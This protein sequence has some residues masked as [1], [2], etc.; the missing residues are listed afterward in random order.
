MLFDC[1]GARRV[2]STSACTPFCN[3]LVGNRKPN[4][5]RFSSGSKF[6]N[7]PGI[8]LCRGTFADDTY[9]LAQCRRHIVGMVEKFKL[10][11]DEIS[12]PA[13]RK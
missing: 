5:S 1:V 13:N 12:Q 10:D 9:Q 2:I 3:T 8:L 7:I 6:Q 11:M 4:L